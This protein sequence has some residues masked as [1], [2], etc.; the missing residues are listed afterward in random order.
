MI[1]YMRAHSESLLLTI[2]EEG[3][4]V[5]IRDEILLHR[6]G[7]GSMRQV[8]ELSLGALVR[9]IRVLLGDEWAPQ[10][11]YFSHSAPSDLSLH[12][13]VFNCWMQF[14][15]EFSGLVCHQ[16]DMDRP[17]ATSDPVMAKYAQ[18][19]LESFYKGTQNPVQ[20]E[21]RQLASFLLPS[22]RCSMEQI[23]RHMCVDR[24]TVHRQLTQENTS[25]AS[26]INDMRVELS[27]RYLTQ[28][29]RTLSEISV[30]LGFSG[31]S[32]LAKWHIKHLGMTASQRRQAI[33]GKPTA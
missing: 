32:A 7:T 22:G 25:F 8:I 11:M 29:T 10:G 1:R 15:Y 16:T 3:S 5:T 19:Q 13:R 33:A 17:I 23:A 18:A 9:I 6:P 21:V 30:L 20:H 24:R 4:Y 14:G 26:I 2:D 12:R 27:Q 28:N 31:P